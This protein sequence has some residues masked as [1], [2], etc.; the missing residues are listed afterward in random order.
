S[1]SL[2][3][4]VGSVFIHDKLAPVVGNVCMDMTMIDVTDI[5]DCKE[6]DEVEI[7]GKHLSVQQVAQWAKTIPYEIMTSVSQ[8][9]K[10]VY[11]EE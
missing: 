6:G 10:R 11:V 9:V 5:F 3:N 2:G 8:R 4:G 1:R 7:F